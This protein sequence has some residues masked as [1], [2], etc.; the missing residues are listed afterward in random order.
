MDRRGA[1]ANWFGLISGLFI[2]IPR[3]AEVLT[4]GPD[5]FVT[6]GWGATAH[7]IEAVVYI[8]AGCFIAAISGEALMYRYRRRPQPSPDGE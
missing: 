5:G 1:W 6:A 8:L 7:W 3:V 4:G 2:V